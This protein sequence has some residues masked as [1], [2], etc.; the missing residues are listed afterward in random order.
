[1]PFGEQQDALST[2]G[3]RLVDDV[4][5]SLGE[6]GRRYSRSMA[7]VYPE[8]DGRQPW[9]YLWAA[10]LPC[11]E[12]GE[13][14]PLT[15]I[16]VLRHPLPVK[17]DP[18]QTY[19]IEVDRAS[20]RRWTVRVHD[21]SPR[22]NQ[23]WSPRRGGKAVQG[24]IAICPFCEHVHPKA[25]TRRLSAEG[26][27]RGRAAPR[28]RPGPSRGQAFPRAVRAERGSRGRTSSRA[29]A[30]GAALR[31]RSSGR[32]GRGEFPLGT[33]NV[34]SRPPTVRRRMASSATTDKRS[35]SCAW[36]ASSPSSARSWPRSTG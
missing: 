6:I 10:T 13:R 11:Q 15:G 29:T 18:G 16:L 36:Y 23:P 28:R 30:L 3:S 8:V 27:R 22:D 12:C 4:R 17:N 2:V 24:K 21:G 19:R 14:F 26:L 7:E 20:R 9:G 32:P 35:A 34:I 33:A 31:A 25:T 5:R 1:M